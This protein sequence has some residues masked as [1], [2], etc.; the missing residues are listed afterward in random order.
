MVILDKVGKWGGSQIGKRAGAQGGKFVGKKIGGK[1]GGKIGYKVGHKIGDKVG[2][3]LGTMAGKAAETAI[4]ASMKKGGHVHK[5]GNYRLHKGEYVLP[6]KLKHR[7]IRVIRQ[8]V[9]N[10]SIRPPKI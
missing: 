4:I 8:R 1:Q 10:P 7:D 2:G 9:G 3:K 6:T 5:T